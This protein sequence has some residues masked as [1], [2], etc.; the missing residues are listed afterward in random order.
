M[1]ELALPRPIIGSLAVFRAKKGIDV[2]L[3]AF[4][5]LLER[6]P[7]AHLLL[8]GYVVPGEQ[9]H[10][11][12]LVE[13]Y[14]LAGK[15]TLTGR[16]P[17]GE[18]L[19]YLRAMDVFAFSSLHDGCPNAVLEAMLAGAPIVAARSG[20]LPDMIEDGKDGLLVQPGSAEELCEA[21]EK[22]LSRRGCE[23]GL[24]K[25]RQENGLLRQFAPEREVEEYGEVY[26]SLQVAPGPDGTREG[27][28]YI[29][30]GATYEM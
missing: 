24:W 20:A 23:N 5:M 2:L 30:D 6:I 18:S 13:S 16:I 26:R 3:A 22:I 17:R 15:L 11:D 29:S 9:R 7:G 25:T 8:A 28:H 10:F 14:G 27:C 4:H 19:R 21:M 12:E 1:Q